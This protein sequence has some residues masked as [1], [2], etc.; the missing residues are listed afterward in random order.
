MIA[1][2]VHDLLALRSAAVTVVSQCDAMLARF[3]DVE[4]AAAERPGDLDPAKCGHPAKSR[5]DT[6]CA[7]ST[8]RTWFC[9]AC[10]HT[11]EEIATLTQVA[12]ADATRG[13]G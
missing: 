6:T 4:D 13:E 5:Q 8:Q 10:R 9:A 2:S 11:S 3:G 1:V 7:G 12:A